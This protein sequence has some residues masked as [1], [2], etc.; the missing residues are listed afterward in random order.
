MIELSSKQRK[1]LEK[2]AQP[3]NPVILIGG[4][5]VT[6]A[7]IAQAEKAIAAQELIKIKFNEF[8]DEK[9]ELS[10]QL[11][12]GVK[13]TLVRIIGN[14]AIIYR[15]AKEPNERSFAKELDKASK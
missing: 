3:L 9:K 8:K 7:V 13:G 2:H 11:A 15:E 5:G 4:G 14:V 12:E 10:A 6:D 1:I